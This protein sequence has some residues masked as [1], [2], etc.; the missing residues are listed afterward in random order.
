MNSQPMLREAEVNQPSS[1]L[2]VAEVAALLRCSKAH[3]HHL[4]AGKVRGVS[5]LPSLGLG[6]RRLIM[7]ASFD[8]WLKANE[9]H[10]ETML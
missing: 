2:T 1:V 10:T 4:I 7:R 9:Q 5:P 8:A 6:R 3:V